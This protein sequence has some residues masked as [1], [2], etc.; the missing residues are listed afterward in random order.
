MMHQ[1]KGSL[2]LLRR[3]T[4]PRRRVQKHD[5]TVQTRFDL[6]DDQSVVAPQQVVSSSSSPSFQVK[7]RW[8]QHRLLLRTITHHPHSCRGWEE[9]EDDSAGWNVIMEEVWYDYRL[10]PTGAI[11]FTDTVQVCGRHLVITS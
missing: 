3:Q 8:C 6:L 9:A 2:R 5:A 11:M 10:Q 4:A 7:H 1:F